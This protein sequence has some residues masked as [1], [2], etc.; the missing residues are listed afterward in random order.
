MGRSIVTVAAYGRARNVC[1][2]ACS[3]F[4][5]ERAANTLVAMHQLAFVFPGQG[6]QSVG[7][8]RALATESEAAAR[9]FAAADDALGYSISSLAWDVP[10]EQLDRTDNAQPAI[11]AGSI[12]VLYPHRH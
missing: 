9:V 3:P 6:S 7:M 11:L 10:A 12:A 5:A 8:A 4:M 1:N 2:H